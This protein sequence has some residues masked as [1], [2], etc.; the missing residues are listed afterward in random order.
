M[1]AYINGVP[2]RVIEIRF[3]SPPPSLRNFILNR[4]FV[5]I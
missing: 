2:V 3:S 5:P 1:D 4:I